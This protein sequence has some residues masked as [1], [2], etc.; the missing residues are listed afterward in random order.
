MPE[1]YV[2]DTNTLV[3]AARLWYAFDLIPSVWPHFK[4]GFAQGTM[5]LL[6]YVMDEIVRGA[7][8]L[9]S[10]LKENVPS[11]RIVCC[12]QN[13]QYITAYG[14]IINVITVR[15]AYKQEAIAQW[16]QDGYV[17]P[18][19]IAV[20]KTEGWVIVTEEQ[21]SGGFV[22]GNLHR[23]IKIPDEAAL[24]HVETINIFEMMRRLGI[25]V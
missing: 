10:W 18:W 4:N 19:L 21:S 15:N 16:S 3:T 11:G 13:D 14:E 9:A 17:D 7:D 6:D 1:R 5:I 8:R 25:H 22:Q 2:V 24:F 23:S 20:A 12:S